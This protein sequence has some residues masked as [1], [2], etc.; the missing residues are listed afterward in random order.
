[1][2]V[3][4]L[5]EDDEMGVSYLSEEDCEKYVKAEDL[6]DTKQLLLAGSE[7]DIE[8]C[9]EFDFSTDV[10]EGMLECNS[11]YDTPTSQVTVEETVQAFTKKVPKETILSHFNSLY[12]NLQKKLC[13]MIEEG[14]IL[15]DER[16]SLTFIFDMQAELTLFEGRFGLLHLIFCRKK[17]WN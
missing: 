8:R 14:G 10:G 16:S 13:Q 9:E 11:E 7:A 17:H 5:D 12:D 3:I 4:E 1:M 2:S 6:L 15:L